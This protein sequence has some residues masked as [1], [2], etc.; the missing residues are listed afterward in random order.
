M[1]ELLEGIARDLR[2]AGADVV[3]GPEPPV[4]GR[5]GP[6][7]EAWR[8]GCD[9]FR[10][11][12]FSNLNL[13]NRPMLL[14]APR[15]LGIVN[16]T[17]GVETVDIEAASELGIL[18]ANGSTPENYTSMAEATVLLV[19][20][21]MYRPGRTIEVMQGRRER[22]PLQA[23]RL[24][25]KMLMRRTIGLVGFGRIGRAVAERLQGWGVRLLAWSPRLDPRTLPGFVSSA[26]L[27]GLLSGS[28]VVC[29]LASGGD[30]SRHLIGA[31]EIG[32]MKRGA[33]L[34]NTARGSIVDENALAAALA[35]GHLGGAALDAF[36]QE[37]LP[38]DSPFRSLENVILTPHLIGHT[39]E[40]AESLRPAAMANIAKILAGEEPVH[41]RNPATLRFSRARAA[42]GPCADRNHSERENM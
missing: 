14:A 26:D 25:S 16:P 24:W 35:D 22:P 31:A 27:P 6:F 23:D 40:L 21:L 10:L 28:D 32:S 34:V 12:V 33:F 37:P 13:C 39:A 36:S 7:P 20:M 11:A 19:L 9:R 18:V 42:A 30:A 3:R 2:D 29:I 17:I 41:C 5:I 4:G 1:P 8:D 38:A 15:L